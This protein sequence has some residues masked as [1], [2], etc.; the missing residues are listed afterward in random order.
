M[1]ALPP[2]RNALDMISGKWKLLILIF[3]WEEN[4]HFREIERSIPKLT[5]KVLANELKL[6]FETENKLFRG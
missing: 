5:T 6:M 4:K 1:P 2:V 3:N